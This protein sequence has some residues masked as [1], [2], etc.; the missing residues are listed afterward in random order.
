MKLGVFLYC[1]NDY[2]QSIRC[3]NSILRQKNT[4]IDL[5]L[6]FDDEETKAQVLKTIAPFSPYCIF[7]GERTIKASFLE[8]IQGSST[9]YFILAIYNQVFS[10]GC[11]DLIKDSL[12]DFDGAVVN[13]AC[14][15]N[16][17]PNKVYNTLS[18]STFFSIAPYCYNIIFKT[19]LFKESPLYFNLSYEVQPFFAASYFA[20]AKNILFVDDVFYYK[21][22]PQAK[23][24]FV[25]EIDLDEMSRIARLARRLKKAGKYDCAAKFVALYLDRIIEL[26][27]KPLSAKQKL[28]YFY[29]TLKIGSALL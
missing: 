13:Y 22:S 25:N 9:D 1:G 20:G 3:I 4:N 18:Y 28:R 29:Y 6:I 27:Q 2:N 23:R 14:F 15:K 21:D 17:K 11:F 12:G 26:K 19:K 5:Q 16:D 8:L 24:A 10:M 7:R